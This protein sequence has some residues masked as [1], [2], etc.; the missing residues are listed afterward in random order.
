MVTTVPHILVNNGH[1]WHVRAFDQKSKAFRDFVCTRLQNVTKVS[2][3]E[4]SKSEKIALDSSE[5]RPSDNQWNKI[6]SVVLKPHPVTR[7]PQAIELD[8]D[9]DNGELKLEVRAALLGYLLRQWDIDCSEKASLIGN[10]YQLWLSNVS[11]IKNEL[12]GIA[13]LVIAPGYDSIKK[14]ELGQK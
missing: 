13:D 10:E 11:Q 7:Y 3:L 8:Y 5:L 1:R 4:Q 12:N 2:Q 14:I 9:M 6:V